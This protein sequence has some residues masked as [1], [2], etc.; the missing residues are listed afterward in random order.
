MWAGANLIPQEQGNQQDV[1]LTN[2]VEYEISFSIK[3]TLTVRTTLPG[4]IIYCPNV[5]V[6]VVTFFTKT[7]MTV[8]TDSGLMNVVIV[9]YVVCYTGAVNDGSFT[10][11]NLRESILTLLKSKSFIDE[12]F[13]IFLLGGV[14]RGGV[15]HIPSDGPVF[16]SSYS[17][18][19]N[20]EC[21]S[22]LLVNNVKYDDITIPSTGVSHFVSKGAR[23]VWYVLFFSFAVALSVTFFG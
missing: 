10:A 16:G 2:A 20:L 1:L 4:K 3:D 9:P 23:S 11:W 15:N 17:G 21:P 22:S 5:Q 6:D 19:T 12:K 18:H 8:A 14:L 7:G 13:A